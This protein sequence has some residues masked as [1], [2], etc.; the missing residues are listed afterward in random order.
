MKMKKKERQMLLALLDAYPNPQTLTELSEL[1][2]VSRSYTHY[3]MIE[4]CALY[5]IVQQK[6]GKTFIFRLHA[7]DLQRVKDFF[8]GE[9]LQ[10]SPSM[11]KKAA[12]SVQFMNN[13]ASTMQS[14]RH[15]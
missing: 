4:L 3:I 14:Y 11:T 8:N 15:E 6:R 5:E 7:N 1:A 10:K 9:T 13:L 12:A 2:G